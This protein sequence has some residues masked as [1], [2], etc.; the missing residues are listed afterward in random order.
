[1]EKDSFDYILRVADN[2][3]GMPE[4]IDFENADSLGLK[5]VNILVEQIDGYIELKRDHGTEFTIRFRN[6]KE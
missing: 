3:K 1:M 6:V 2:G 4:E 5:L